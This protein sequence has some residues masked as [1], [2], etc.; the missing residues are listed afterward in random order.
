MVLNSLKDFET[1]LK[2]NIAMNMRRRLIRFYKF[3]DIKEDPVEFADGVLENGDEENF[4]GVDFN[5]RNG[6]TL[7][8]VQ[9]DIN[10]QLE[11][12][13]RAAGMNVPDGLRRFNTISTKAIKAN[14]VHFNI[15]ALTV[16]LN[17][18]ISILNHRIK[19]RNDQMPAGEQN[20]EKIP[21]I[22]KPNS[23]E[24]AREMFSSVINFKKFER[25]E[26]DPDTDDGRIKRK[27]VL[28]FS[29][30][31]VSAKLGMRKRVKPAI[32]VRAEADKQI[33]MDPG[34]V[35]MFSAVSEC[36][37]TKHRH[38]AFA[39]ARSSTTWQEKSP[40]LEAR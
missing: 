37:Y 1:A 17:K 15:P 11:N 7:I 39:R 22:A 10:T 36:Q 33:G 32:P 21:A 31:L 4:P 26:L 9:S 20:E 5:T 12:A 16:K 38:F 23:I 14:F 28:C 6:Y 30:D 3:I 29:T 2:N 24:A 25:Y 13:I 34:Y 40:P 8:P 27:L 19:R 35:E 18:R